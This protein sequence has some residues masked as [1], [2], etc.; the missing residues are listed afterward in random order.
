MFSFPFLRSRGALG[1]RSE[2]CSW[3]VASKY[4]ILA[5]QVGLGCARLR[6]SMEMRQLVALR[7]TLH[8]LSP[9]NP[10]PH[11]LCVTRISIIWPRIRGN[12][13]FGDEA[14]GSWQQVDAYFSPLGHSQGAGRMGR[15]CLF[16]RLADSGVRRESIQPATANDGACIYNRSG[17][18][19]PTSRPSDQGTLC[20]SA[21]ASWPC[22]SLFGFQGAMADS[23]SAPASVCMFSMLCVYPVSYYHIECIPGQPHLRPRPPGL[24]ARQNASS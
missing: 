2:H 12:M 4:E 6:R 19:H 18:P 9:A 23:T 1:G 21:P 20:L 3:D 15:A 22:R 11:T 10:P 24:P 14:A 13:G 7:A 17:K 8:P 16:P 5:L